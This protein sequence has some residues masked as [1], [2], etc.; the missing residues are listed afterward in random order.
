MV[1]QRVLQSETIHL[2][3]LIQPTADLSFQSLQ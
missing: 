2:I 1:D 3:N